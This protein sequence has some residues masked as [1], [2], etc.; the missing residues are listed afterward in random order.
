MKYGANDQYRITKN[1]ALTMDLSRVSSCG[2]VKLCSITMR[3]CDDDFDCRQCNV[4]LAEMLG[5][6]MA[7]IFCEKTEFYK[8]PRCIKCGGPNDLLDASHLCSECK[9]EEEQ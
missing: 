7:L 4:M 5:R 3:R 2:E 6:Q 9:K 8:M 1:V